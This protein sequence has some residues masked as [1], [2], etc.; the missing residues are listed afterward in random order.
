MVS[1]GVVAGDRS[2]ATGWRSG[3]TSGSGTVVVGWG[4]KNVGLS[5]WTG[6]SSAKA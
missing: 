4:S 1:G 5:G 6:P 2:S 3:L